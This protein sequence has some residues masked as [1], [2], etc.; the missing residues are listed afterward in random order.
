MRVGEFTSGPM[1]RAQLIQ[2]G[3]TC[4]ERSRIPW[5]RGAQAKSGT[6]AVIWLPVKVGPLRDRCKTPNGPGTERA[7]ANRQSSSL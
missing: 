2:D 6:L 5:A 3:T 1:S 4:G 7:V